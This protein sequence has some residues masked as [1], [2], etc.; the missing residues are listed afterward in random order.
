M[1]PQQKEVTNGFV[2]SKVDQEQEL[3]LTAPLDAKEAKDGVWTV[4]LAG[5]GLP[6]EAGNFTR[7]WLIKEDK[8]GPG[9]TAYSQSPDSIL[10]RNV[11]SDQLRPAIAM[12][13]DNVNNPKEVAIEITF[14]EEFVQGTIEKN[15]FIKATHKDRHAWEI[16]A[17]DSQKDAK[18][19]V[20]P[21]NI[22]M[23]F[24]KDNGIIGQVSQ[25][26]T[27]IPAGRIAASLAPLAASIGSTLIRGDFAY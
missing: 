17:W 15:A 22:S 21:A 7:N 6:A 23:Y 4:T 3:W 16:Q 2:Q 26:G 11:Y 27:V 13:I 19:G 25:E 5:L 1:A 9:L 20:K 12:H 10:E 14:P 8:K 24:T 18:D